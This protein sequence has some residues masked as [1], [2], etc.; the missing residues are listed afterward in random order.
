M[1]GF[2]VGTYGLVRAE[3]YLLEESLKV[4]RMCK[5]LGTCVAEVTE[6]TVS[7]AFQ[8]NKTGEPL[9]LSYSGLKNILLTLYPKGSDLWGG[10]HS[11]HRALLLNAHFDSAMSSPGAADCASC[12]GVALESAR[13]LAASGP[14]GKVAFLLNG[15]EE[16]Y[17]NAVHGFV[18]GHGKRYHKEGYK[19]AYFAFINLEATGSYGPDVVFRAN[20]EAL[21]RSYVRRAPRPR[22]TVIAQ[23]IFG[24]GVVPSDTD[25]S[26]LGG[27][28]FGN[29]TGMD[30]ATMFDSRSYHCARDT[31]DRIKRGSLQAYGDNVLEIVKDVS[32]GLEENDEDKVGDM[33]YFDILGL[34]VVSYS[35]KVTFFLHNLP[36]VLTAFVLDKELLFGSRNRIKFLLAV[37]KGILA[38]CLSF[39][40]CL[41]FPAA[42]ALL[43]CAPS[44]EAAMTWYGKPGV[45]AVL[46]FPPALAGLLLPYLVLFMGG[47]EGG[48]KG[49]GKGLRK[50]SWDSFLSHCFGTL[51]VFSALSS[52]MTTNEKGIM[53]HS[54]YIFA[55]FSFS[56]LACLAR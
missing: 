34:G 15:G 22:A 53:G 31:Y 21:L 37:L 26:V 1:L 20:S 41:V 54:G 49:S 25:Y 28:Q 35:P 24:S 39:A 13:A 29:L 33:V 32:A 12:V 46:L 17:M 14:T 45:A 52:Y 56:T 38:C 47:G 6:D 3:E 43:A 50:L 19:D 9:Y 8:Y 11:D 55:Y 44:G 30:L 18:K 40:C 27:E 36:L 16:I 42:A 51:L 10:N 23:D 2:Q 5:E 7:G 4:K 48:N